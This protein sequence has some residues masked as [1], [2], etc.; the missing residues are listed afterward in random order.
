MAVSATVL[1]VA[2]GLLYALMRVERIGRDSIWHAAVLSRLADQF[3]RDVHTA[4]GLNRQEDLPGWRLEIAPD[5]SVDYRLHAGRIDRVERVDGTVQRRESFVLPP[6]MSAS[7]ETS[8]TEGQSTVVRLRVVPAEKRLPSETIA[9]SAGPIGQQTIEID[10]V[11]ARDRRF[12]KPL[13]P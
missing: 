13:E 5:R 8:Q 3:R 4:D 9:E 6:G 7:I 10:A 12:E 1:A 2:V 11:L